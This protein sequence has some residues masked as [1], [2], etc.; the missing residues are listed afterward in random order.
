MYSSD[1]L[2][3]ITNIILKQMPD[4]EAIYLFGSYAKGTARNDS[5]IDVAVLLHKILGWKM[6]KKILNQIYSE[7]GKMGYDVDFIIKSKES[8]DKEKNFPTLS[9]IISREGKI[10]WIK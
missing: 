6:R 7:T 9:R 1:D 10:L 5:D 3:K 2:K 4:A 8:F